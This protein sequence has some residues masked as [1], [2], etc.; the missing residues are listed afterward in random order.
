MKR[1][2]CFYAVICMVQGLYFRECDFPIAFLGVEREM[3]SQF[4]T[5]QYLCLI[6]PFFVWVV[7][8]SDLFTRFYQSYGIVILTRSYQKGVFVSSLVKKVFL[9]A[10]ALE[11]IQFVVNSIVFCQKI[12]AVY[13]YMIICLCFHLLVMVSITLMEVLLSTFFRNQLLIIFSCIYIYLSCDVA[14]RSIHGIL[15]IIFYSGNVV[16]LLDMIHARDILWLVVY[17]VLV[18]VFVI[19]VC[20]LFIRRRCDVIDYI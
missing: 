15:G 11:G 17:G 8:F 7:I 13:Q 12:R 16:C 4:T 19:V 5:I 18:P 1:M 9:D 6:C 10:I 2:C 20:Y 3:L 14:G